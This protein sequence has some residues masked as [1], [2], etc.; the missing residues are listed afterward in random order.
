M[1]LKLD[2]HKASYC[3]FLFSSEDKLGRVLKSAL[4]SLV[5]SPALAFSG[6]VYHGPRAGLTMLTL[7]PTSLLSV[8]TDP[9]QILWAPGALGRARD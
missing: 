4:S 3:C 9:S 1:L 7:L 8:L 5:G 2:V 6:S